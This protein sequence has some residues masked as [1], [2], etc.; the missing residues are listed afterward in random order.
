MLCLHFNSNDIQDF[1]EVSQFLNFLKRNDEFSTVAPIFIVPMIHE[2]YL[3]LVFHGFL[4]VVLVYLIFIEISIM[5]LPTT[6]LEIKT[7]FSFRI[8]FFIY[9]FKKS[10]LRPEKIF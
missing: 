1:D 7:Y 8:Y 10:R 4:I 2:Q 3:F 5:I 6:H 9:D